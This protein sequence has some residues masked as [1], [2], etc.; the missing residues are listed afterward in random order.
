MFFFKL[1]VILGELKTHLDGLKLSKSLR[2]LV[3]YEKNCFV[4]AIRL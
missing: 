3:V 1:Y 2:E 4:K